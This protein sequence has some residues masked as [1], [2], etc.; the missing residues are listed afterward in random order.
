MLIRRH[1]PRGPPWGRREDSRGPDFWAVLAVFAVLVCAVGFVYG[2]AIHAPFVFD[3]QSSI[4][5]NRSIVR[6]RPLLGEGENPGPLTP[7]MNQVTSGRPL[8]NLSYALNYRFGRL[9][10]TGYHIVNLTLHALSAT[11]LFGVVCNALRLSYF[12]GRYSRVAIPLSFIVALVWALH[13]LQTDAVEYVS[14]RTELMVG[15]FYLATFFASQRYFA[16][17]TGRGRG[18]WLLT[19]ALGCSLG[20]ACKELMVTAPAMILLYERTFIAGSFR[21]ALRDS[22]PL[23]VG[24]FLSWGVI[25]ALNINGPRSGTA[26]FHLALS[27]FVW[28]LTQAK[29]FVIYMKLVVWPWPLVIHYHIPYLGSFWD[30]WP[31]LVPV[32]IL[33]IV[34]LERLWRR[35]AIGFLGAWVFVILSPT[36]VVP[37]LTEVAAERRMYLP[38]AALVTLAMVLLF[39]VVDRVRRDITADAGERTQLNASKSE[40]SKVWSPIVITTVCAVLL[41]CV[42]GFVSMVR[43]TAYR[44]NWTLW[45][46]AVAHQPDDPVANYSA[47]IT[48]M[49]AGKPHDAIEYFRRTLQLRSKDPPPDSHRYFGTVL[50]AVGANE[51]AIAEL[52]QALEEEPDA[53]AVRSLL[54][55]TLVNAGRHSEAIVQLER[56]LRTKPDSVE[57]LDHLGVALFNAGRM[58]EAIGRLE[59]ATR[60]KPEYLSARVNLAVAYAKA[61]RM[62]EAIATAEKAL[63]EA[64]SQGAT[65]DAA[66]IEVWLREFR[67]SQPK[68]P[69]KSG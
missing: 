17:T 45:Q 37:I 22:W 60:L 21:R 11:L 31:W 56:I 1:R 67:R 9:D 30:A 6:L 53:I 26:G 55:V 43:L 48:L 51:E 52:Q 20:A 41:A 44:E 15:F 2:G 4:T 46:D 8:V 50:A 40:S 25:L 47:G 58:S 7:E 28:W 38:L 14:Q 64:R 36:L 62:A 39:E 34:V 63:A 29:V 16:A 24:L 10:P 68:T 18:L 42:L 33:G 32:E 61:G 12:G 69:A 49:L 35:K 23:Y 3:D 19:A 65:K 13:P 66:Q 5:Q 54:G 27:P 59:Q 57:D